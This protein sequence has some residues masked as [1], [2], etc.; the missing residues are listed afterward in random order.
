MTPIAQAIKDK[1][2]KLDLIKIKA[3]MHQTTPS[4]ILKINPQNKAKYLQIIYQLKEVYSEY[5]LKKLL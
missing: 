1:I 2:G 3:F 4:S 5:L